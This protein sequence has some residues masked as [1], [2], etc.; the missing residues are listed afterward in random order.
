MNDITRIHIAKTAYDIEITAKKQLEKYI[1][2]LETYTQDADVLTD[3]EIR[4][5]E[6]LA[7]RGVEAN[8]VI[9]S[10][11]V[12]AVRAQLG[13]PYEFAGEEGDIAVGPV[14][15][16]TT[17][18]LYRST[19]NAVLG[20]VLSG[21]AAYFNVNPLWTRLVFILLLFISFGVASVAYILFWILTPAART[22]TEKLQLAGKDVTVESI[23]ELNASEEPSRQNRLAPALKQ[24]LSV[25]FGGVSAL[26]SLGVFV[27][28][29]WMVVAALTF[30]PHFVDITNGF[31]GLGNEN[32]WLVWFVFWMVVL[33]LLLLAGLFGLVAYAFF[34]KKLTKR[35]VVSGIVI[36][37]LGLV[38]FATVLG[39]SAT[40][41][42]RVANE[43]RALVRETTTN[44][45]K[46][47]KNVK[48]VNFEVLTEKTSAGRE[49]LFESF[50]TI[51]YVVDEETAR[52]ELSAL[53]T[54]KPTIAIDGTVATVSLVIPE[55]FRNAFVQ[56]TIT[57]YGPELDAI[58]AKSG[59]IGYAGITQK[60]FSI[61]TEEGANA[62]ISGAFSEVSVIGS[63]SVNLDSSA[64]QML[65]VRANQNLTVTAG[66]V[67]EL[68]VT[69]PEVCPSGT[70]RDTT[71]VTVAGVTQKNM[72]YNG[73][74][75]PAK[76]HETSCASI[77]V[78]EQ[79]SYEN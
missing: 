30:E 69:Q 43:S 56:P 54:A 24:V 11:D 35:M 75:M 6:L 37:A 17:R 61:T 72:T 9:G 41:S 20:G 38:S 19:E 58:S 36:T 34:A 15:E 49:D 25:G 10:D 50:G 65:D 44:L 27:A 57:M 22:A 66:T 1:K 47:F 45:P 59:D 71:S 74:V 8:G 73:T 28:T 33:G 7:E 48:T 64:V 79:E 55:S 60:N 23:R 2:S 62:T 18:R 4:I 16:T 52:Y 68:K 63:G 26:A 40:Q 78:D 70:Q 76:S 5:T 53:P 51:R 12:A 32:M 42:Y 13:E 21:I 77:V 46:E 3:I 31:A 29:V 14:A 39:I 67:R